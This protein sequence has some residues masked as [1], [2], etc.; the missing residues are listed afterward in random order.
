MLRPGYGLG[1]GELMVADF[2]FGE[3]DGR[4][5]RGWRRF[6][7]RPRAECRAASSATATSG[8]AIRSTWFLK[9]P[10]IVQHR[11]A[12]ELR[13]PKSEC[14]G[15]PC[16]RSR[17]VAESEGCVPCRAACDPSSTKNIFTCTFFFTSSYQRRKFR[18]LAPKNRRARSRNC[19]EAFG[20]LVGALRR[21]TSVAVTITQGL[22]EL[23][24]P[25]CSGRERR[26][27]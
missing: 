14:R 7:G 19:H 20:R 16:V 21:P 15:A 12:P 9:P 8:T 1:F 22:V 26:V 13:C 24:R 2:G 25:S 11:I 18:P 4:R 17:G 3:R 6:R 10:G 23:L 27:S 5:A